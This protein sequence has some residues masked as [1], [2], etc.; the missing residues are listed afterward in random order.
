MTQ[1]VECERCEPG[2]LA[3]PCQRALLVGTAPRLAIRP[4][5]KNFTWFPAANKRGEKGLPFIGQIDVT[6]L[7][8]L[9]GTNAN[10]ASI[11]I[12]VLNRERRQL[13]ISATGDKRS[14]YEIPKFWLTRIYEPS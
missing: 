5:Q 1:F 14:F 8:A 2:R 12:Q 6:R 3:R 9:A 4:L 7:A 13:A 11:W 10:C